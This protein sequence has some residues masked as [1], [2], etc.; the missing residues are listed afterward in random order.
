MVLYRIRMETSMIQAHHG[1]N[2][3]C[4][5]SLCL[6]YFRRVCHESQGMPLLRNTIL[7]KTLIQGSKSQEHDREH[8]CHIHLLARSGSLE[9]RRYRC[10]ATFEHFHQAAI[11]GRSPKSRPG[12]TKSRPGR[13]SQPR[14]HES[15][16]SVQIKGN[17]VCKKMRMQGGN[18]LFRV[19]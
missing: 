4:R 11:C 7:R 6:N 1:N 15:R 10:Q 14:P 16:V 5:S 17:L 3:Q 19:L 18:G 13:A 12:M 9:G 8:Y 2:F